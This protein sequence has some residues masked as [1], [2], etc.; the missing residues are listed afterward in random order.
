[1][2]FEMFIAG[3]YLRSRRR[4]NFISLISL[5]S[6]TGVALGVIALDCSLSMMNGFETEI[7]QRIVE[8]TA[9]ISVYSYSGEGFSDWRS[10]AEKVQEVPEVLGVAPGIYAKSVIGSSQ[11]NEGVYVKGIIPEEEVKVSRLPE[12]IVAGS[13]S[14]EDPNDSLPGIVIGRELASTLGVKIKDEIVLASL[15][16]KKLSITIQPK[17]KRFRVTGIFETGFN[18]YDATLVYIA[19]PVAQDLFKLDSLVTDLQVKVT[20]VYRSREIAL[21]VEEHVGQPYYA[22]DWSERHK[23]LFS[24]MTLE[25][26]GMA[27]ILGLIVLVAAFGIVST[28]VMLVLQKRQEIAILKS[29]GA[30]QRQVMRIFV[31][32]GTLLGIVGTVAGTCIGFLACW[33]QKEFNLVSIPSEIYFIN[34]L[35]IDMRLHEFVLIA[36][37]SVL[38]SFLA[39]LYPSRRASRLFPSDILRHG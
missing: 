36:V 24:W 28:L 7:R 29:M 32:Q 12:N 34:T 27:L 23:N 30:T 31:I 3:R 25:K 6:I 18:E 2:G 17:Y 4:E 26:Y 5:I 33:L 15:K 20:D 37:S 8:T 1:L 19:M 14:L 13:L 38:I 35:P 21:R 11:A 39:T 10:L 22:V 9:H 16:Q